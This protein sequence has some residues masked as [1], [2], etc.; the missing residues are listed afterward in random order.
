MGVNH[1]GHFYLTHLL[2]PLIKKAEEPRIINL[3]SLGHQGTGL[4]FKDNTTIDFTDMNFKNQKYRWDIAYSRSKMANVLFTRQL[5]A[6]MDQAG[7]KG[8]SY[9]LH[10]GCIAT[11]MG[12]DLG[13]Y[14]VLIMRI[15]YFPLIFLF[16]KTDNQG[17]Q[18]TLHLLLEDTSK[19]SKGDYY[20]DCK[21]Y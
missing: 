12:R 15:V 8:Y 7:I 6:K 18:T 20:K 9:S 13:K 4:I 14:A 11:D 2:W 10:P 17:V 1:L 21:R 3:S 16:F 19:L 5:Q